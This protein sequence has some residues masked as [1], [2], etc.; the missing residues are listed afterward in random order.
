MPRWVEFSPDFTK[1]RWYSPRKGKNLKTTSVNLARIQKIHV[2]KQSSVTLQDKSTA[3][4][5]EYL[6]KNDNTSTLT[7]VAESQQQAFLWF[8]AI[9]MCGDAAKRGNQMINAEANAK[10]AKLVSEKNPNANRSV[11][12]DLPGSDNKPPTVN[13][14]EKLLKRANDLYKKVLPLIQGKKGIV[15]KS[16]KK[17]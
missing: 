1:L 11:V 4:T 14:L 5:L 16:L 6:D 2:G 15:M 3:F 8:Q 12:L 9:K 10:L 17:V 7:L 13:D